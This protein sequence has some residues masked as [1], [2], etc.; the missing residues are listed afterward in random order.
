MASDIIKN[1]LKK[2]GIENQIKKELK[3]SSVAHS[4]S[5]I[6][7]DALKKQKNKRISYSNVNNS[8]LYKLKEDYK[9]QQEPTVDVN[10]IHNSYN[11]LLN[12][13]SVQNPFIISSGLVKII[14]KHTRKFQGKERKARAIYDWIE[15]NIEYG[16]KKRKHGYQNSKETLENKE[17]ICGEMAF[18]YITMARCCSLRSAC[19]SVSV[20]YKGKKVHHACAIVDVGNRDIYVDP[21]YHTF[22]IQHKKYE[23]LTDIEVLQRFNQWRNR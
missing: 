15:K 14:K 18:V 6:I 19:V 22:D 13:E 1:S 5:S 23:I 17:G 7:V 11:L 10:D 21:A 2:Q 16:T 20:D 8:I 4:S 3:K 12:D 9:K